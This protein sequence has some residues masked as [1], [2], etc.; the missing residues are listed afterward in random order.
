MNLTRKEAIKLFREHW[1]WLAETG[2]INKLEFLNIK[3]HFV[4]VN[5]YLCDYVGQINHY[6]GL[7]T[8]CYKCPIVWL[9][10][11]NAEG[12]APCISSYYEDWYNTEIDDEKTRKALAR[13]ISL[14]PEKS[15]YDVFVSTLKHFKERRK[16]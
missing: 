8:N 9:R 13:E 5:C 7:E 15:H 6:Y 4:Y 12:F 11:N 1:S 3:K 16:E 2:S 14:L 10:T